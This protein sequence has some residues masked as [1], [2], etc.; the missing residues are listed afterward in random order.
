MSGANAS[1]LGRSNQEMSAANASPLG[2]S[3]RGM[4]GASF[5]FGFVMARALICTPNP[6]PATLLI[7]LEARIPKVLVE[8]NPE[9]LGLP[10][11]HGRSGA[12]PDFDAMYVR[13]PPLNSFHCEK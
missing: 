12:P 8:C 13:T 11:C 6:T 9:H 7:C 4:S 3:N 5:L 10:I 2:R 1:P